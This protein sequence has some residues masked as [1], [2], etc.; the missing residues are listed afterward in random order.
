MIASEVIIIFFYTFLTGGMA[1]IITNNV[2]MHRIFQSQ[3][4][5]NTRT[6]P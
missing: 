4:A 2:V 1:R 5:S 3:F 6:L